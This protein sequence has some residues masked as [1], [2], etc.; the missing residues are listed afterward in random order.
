MIVLQEL[1]YRVGGRLGPALLD[2]ASVQIPFGARVGLVGRNG[3]GKS[4]L[5]DLIRG[6]LLPERGDVILPKDHR[7]GFL[8]QEAPAGSGTPIATVLAADKERAAMLRELDRG[9]APLRIGEIEAR[10]HEIGARSAP[11]RAARILAGLGFDPAMQEAP[12]DDL[13]GGWRMR[14][15]LAAVLFA[16]PDL[17]LL[18]EPT[19]HLD[20]E[21]SLWLERFLKRYRHSFILVSH[22]RQLLNAAPETILHLEGGKLTLYSGNFDS[23]LRARREAIARQAAVAKRQE[24]QRAHMQAFVD[25]FR[26]KASKARQA[27]SRLKALAKLEPVAQMV[28]TAPPQLDL[29]QPPELAPP[30]ITLDRVT[31][32]YTADRPILSK[33][34]LR[35]DPDD[36]IALLGANGNGK[37]TFAR[38]LAGRLAPFS[39]TLTRSP[40]LSVGFFTQHQIEEMRPDETAVDHLA[41]VAPRLTPEQVRTR[42]GAFGFGQQKALVSVGDLSGGER[43]RL[44]LAL[45]T[46][47][48]PSLLIL[49]EPTNHLDIET[50]EALVEALNDYAGAVVLVSHDWHLVELVAERLWLVADGTVRPFDGDLEEYRRLLLAPETQGE[51]G[52]EPAVN[53]RR[54]Q[55]REA[56]ERRLAIEPLRREARR[57]EETAQRLS[58]ERQA[59]DR[60]LTAPNSQGTASTALADAYRR[61]AEL[62]RLIEEA[63]AAW[64]AAEEAIESAAIS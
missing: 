58:A 42:L 53:D 23:Y 63:E 39:G 14:V 9:A 28:A 45:V 36:R 34:D 41:A 49:D 43:A 64:L 30:I 27:Q 15:A 8:A 56:A 3:A 19:N 22:D 13:S 51:G 62:T 48:A 18:D 16:E 7:I 54:N 50:R 20:L 26:Y 44:N 61:R 4:T 55:R 32:G 60:R 24:A 17:L 31:T 1:T 2:N 6:A 38:L 35:L 11:A 21:A 33:L 25:R 57:A 5:I 46:Y 12:L 59:L 52:R 40:K 29:P 47:D 10:L 37:T